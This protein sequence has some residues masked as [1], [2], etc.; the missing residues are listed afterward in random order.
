M[1]LG[2]DG[3]DR[4]AAPLKPGNDEVDLSEIFFGA[5][6]GRLTGTI[7]ALPARSSDPLLKWD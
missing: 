5:F 1:Y 2:F 6:S 3:M 4:K 7:C